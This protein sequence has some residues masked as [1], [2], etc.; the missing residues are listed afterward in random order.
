MTAS[1][2]VAVQ[3][4]NVGSVIVIVVV[5]VQLFASVTVNECVPAARLYVPVLE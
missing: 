4:S 2:G 1:E 5:A 3:I